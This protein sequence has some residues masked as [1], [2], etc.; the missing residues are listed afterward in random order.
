M[1][2]FAGVFHYG[3]RAATA[4]DAF[5]IAK[6]LSSFGVGGQREV[7]SGSV[8]MLSG[9]L[10]TNRESPIDEQ[11]IRSTQGHV[12]FF[13]GRLDNR[14]SLLQSLG[15]DP[16]FPCSD[17]SLV[18]DLYERFGQG[19]FRGLIGDFAIALWDAQRET[20]IL[21]RDAFGVRALYYRP[22]S[23]RVVWST[24]LGHLLAISDGS[25]SLDNEY[26]IDFL[27]R[28]PELDRTPY[29]GVYAVPPASAVVVRGGKL[30][31]SRYWSPD[32]R[33]LIRYRSDEEYEEH[34]SNL[35]RESVRNR[36]RSKGPICADLSGGIDSSSIVCVADDL[37]KSGSVPATEVIPISYRFDE[38]H[39]ADEYEF[40]RSV[41]EKIGKRGTYLWES[42]FRMLSQFRAQPFGAIPNLMWLYGRREQLVANVMR[43]NHANVILR[44]TGGDHLMLSQ[45]SYPPELPDYL[46]TG[47]LLKLH[48]TIA[49]WKASLPR[50]YLDFMLKGA[51]SPL[52]PAKLSYK[53]AKPRHSS[54]FLLQKEFATR[55][56]A[57][58]RMQ[59][60]VE[61][62][63]LRYPP[64]RHYCAVLLT[65]L[66][67]TVAGGAYQ[68]QP[69][70]FSLPY[71]DRPL[72][73]FCLAIP[74]QQ[75]IRPGITRSLQR[76][77]MKPLLPPKV[78]ERT[79]KGRLGEA[80]SRAWVREVKGLLACL[81]DTEV[82]ARGYI[83]RGLFHE[84]LMKSLHGLSVDLTPLIQVLCLEFWLRSLD[85]G[86]RKRC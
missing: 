51:L 49:A 18:L 74:V 48:Q 28:E 71:L 36:L 47:R 59:K 81:Q 60:P 63:G 23:D 45:V 3:Q 83:D 22:S 69:Y 66:I 8:V 25:T 40:I 31:V 61:D 62:F 13:N 7:L 77:A 12:G 5:L 33:H 42:E 6:R 64:S 26:V 58:E 57:V 1:R 38:S 14:S 86:R 20:I 67:A 43:S 4:E 82:C 73:E 39:S 50:P 27:L 53:L 78:A 79:T 32:P 11:P 19:S 15:R 52:L 2:V 75:K 65:D 85:E 46:L 54:L 34:Y 72:V 70:E 44:G 80:V 30:Q 35:F 84:A 68:E 17:V 56:R 29:R 10:F 41:E 16:H 24:D 9:M 21:V 55:M 37:V 76:R